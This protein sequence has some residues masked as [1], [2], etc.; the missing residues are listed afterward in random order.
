MGGQRIARC[1]RLLPAFPPRPTP[2]PCPLPRPGSAQV[3]YDAL[4]STIPLDITLRWLGKDEWADGLE[5]SSSHII[6]IGEGASRA[7]R[8]AACPSS[9]AAACGPATVVPCRTRSASAPVALPAVP[10]FPSAPFYRPAAAAAVRPSPAPSLA[11]LPGPPP[12]LLL[13]VPP[14]R[15]SCLPL[16]P[17]LPPPAGIR[18]RCPHGLKCWLYFPEDDCPFYRTTVFSHYAKKNCPAGGRPRGCRAA[19]AWAAA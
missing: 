4:I 10:A 7:P 14:A 15:P 11:M 18:G 8:R 1:P 6:G 16:R 17:R 9:A 19:A 3:A 12:S 5:H 2:G 13:A